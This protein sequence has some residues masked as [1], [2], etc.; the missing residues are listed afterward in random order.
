MTA[1][2]ATRPQSSEDDPLLPA[3]RILLRIAREKRA[4]RRAAARHEKP[5]PKE[6]AAR[7]PLR[8]AAPLTS[9]SLTDHPRH[10]AEEEAKIG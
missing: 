9:T 5:P 7:A 6:E 3:Y 4:A 2:H 1:L 10:R 8:T